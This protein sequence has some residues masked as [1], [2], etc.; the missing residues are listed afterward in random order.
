[1]AVEFVV[2]SVGVVTIVVV[3]VVVSNGFKSNFDGGSLEVADVN[4]FSCSCLASA[5][6]FR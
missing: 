1:M 4:S 2:C 6:P 5:T 3:N